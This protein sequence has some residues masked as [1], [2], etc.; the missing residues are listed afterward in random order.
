MGYTHYMK[1]LK[2]TLIKEEVKVIKEII[3]LAPCMIADGSGTVGSM[4][5]VTSK[6]IC[7]NGAGK[8]S[9]ETFSIV[10]GQNDFN[11]C[12]TA[13]KPYDVVCVAILIFLK[14]LGAIEW[15]SD[16]GPLDFIAGDDL[17]DKALKIEKY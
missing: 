11:F 1:P 15:S 4:P 6:E 16:G 2:R 12:K 13:Q 10:H 3:K 5:V 7:L 9:Y 8:D 14:R 17:L